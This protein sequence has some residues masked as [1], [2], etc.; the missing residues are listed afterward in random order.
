MLMSCSNW[1]PSVVCRSTSTTGS[2]RRITPSTA[3]TSGAS[4]LTKSRLRLSRAALVR[5]PI[6]SGPRWLTRWLGPKRSWPS[7]F[8]TGTNTIDTA[9]SAP[10]ASLPSSRSRSAG[11]PA[12]LPS[13]L[14]AWGALAPHGDDRPLL[15][16]AADLVAVHA[17]VGAREVAAQLHRLVVAAGA[18]VLRALGGG[19][20]RGARCRGARGRRGEAHERMA[21]GPS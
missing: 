19:G 14:R 1:A 5:K 12:A 4:A 10:G 20:Q 16:A 3:W 17:A 8:I 13:I 2:W 9:S 7:G 6:S 15:D 11:N 21:H 18:H